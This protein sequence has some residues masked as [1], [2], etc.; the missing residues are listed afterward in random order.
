MAIP[1][2]NLNILYVMLQCQQNLNG[3]QRDMRN[4]ALTWLAQAQA[5]SVPVATLAGFMNNAAAS[6]Q[7]RLGWLTTLEADPNWPAIGAMWGKLGGTAQ[8]FSNVI[9]PLTAVV[10][11]L[12]PVDKS[13]YAAIIT[14]CNEIIAA[15][16]APLSLWPE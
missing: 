2:T 4:N 10:N 7:N 3:L 13:T 9:T 11:Q 16:N 8:D 6:Y 12:G 15:I 14:A 5:Q 1:V